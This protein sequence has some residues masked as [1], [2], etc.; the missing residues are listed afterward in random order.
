MEVSLGYGSEMQRYEDALSQKGKK[1]L[2]LICTVVGKGPAQR[3][4]KLN[5]K[6]EGNSG[7]CRCTVKL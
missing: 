4:Q 1:Y 5:E 7:P 2:L 6:K 3:M